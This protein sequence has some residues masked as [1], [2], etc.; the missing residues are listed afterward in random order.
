MAPPGKPGDPMDAPEIAAP[1]L[2][3]DGTTPRPAPSLPQEI[4][5]IA[6]GLVKGGLTEETTLDEWSADYQRRV[7]AGEAPGLTDDPTTE[8]R[9]SLVADFMSWI[10][11]TLGLTTSQL[12]RRRQK[13]HD[14]VRDQL[15]GED[16]EPYS[17]LN[18]ED[19]Q[20]LDDDP[21]L[22][23]EE[24]VQPRMIPPPRTDAA[25][26]VT[27]APLDERDNGPPTP[28]EDLEDLTEI[29]LEDLTAETADEIE[30][31]T[32]PRKPPVM[33]VV[34][35][36][37]RAFRRFKEFPRD[38]QERLIDRWVKET[39]ITVIEGEEPEAFFIRMIHEFSQLPNPEDQE[40][41]IKGVMD[42]IFNLGKR[43]GP[44]RAVPEP[45]SIGARVR[46]GLDASFARAEATRRAHPPLPPTPEVRDPGN[47]TGAYTQAELK[48]RLRQLAAQH[49]TPGQAT[50]RAARPVRHD[51]LPPAERPRPQVRIR[52]PQEHEIVAMPEAPPD[53][54][55]PLPEQPTAKPAPKRIKQS[56]R[57]WWD[58][59]AQLSW[60]LPWNWTPFR[61]SF[62]IDM[63]I[64]ED[65]QAESK[66]YE[67]A[68]HDQPPVQEEVPEVP[69][70]PEPP[71]KVGPVNI[72]TVPPSGI[73][74]VTHHRRLL[75]GS[76]R[77]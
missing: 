17:D 68:G 69:Q 52:P 59:L 62:D 71:A 51:S 14:A 58:R 18:P 46:A 75:K 64:E 21:G 15:L 34:G 6:N 20:P 12:I 41:E 49:D 7:A 22:S 23:E 70:P 43:V 35:I 61:S 26:D 32:D 5:Q 42:D 27:E 72:T 1:M 77:H 10:G 44:T 45:G 8:V 37:A 60:L 54:V 2:L 48:E 74:T 47:A 50:P 11:G 36:A 3:E 66:F 76:R 31:R 63:T 4:I 67:E 29:R 56:R 33:G 24:R 30:A 73:I 25:T 38:L 57:S 65:G 19:L 16:T 53:D 39:A 13:R 9:R 55:I 40:D 28:T